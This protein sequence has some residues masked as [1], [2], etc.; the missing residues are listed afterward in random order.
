M[1]FRCYLCIHVYCIV[2][3]MEK[4]KKIVKN[5]N[6]C[7]CPVCDKVASSGTFGCVVCRLWVHPKCGDYTLSYTSSRDTDKSWLKCNNCKSSSV[8]NPESSSAE[9]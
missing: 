5:A 4:C 3:K 2:S 6:D 8:N 9:S 7:I 1:L